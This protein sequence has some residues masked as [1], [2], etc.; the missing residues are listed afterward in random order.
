M[1]L[2]LTTLLTTV[3]THSNCVAFAILFTVLLRTGL[4][5][6]QTKTF[7]AHAIQMSEGGKK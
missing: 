7:A 6:P 2:S 3:R 5:R 4:G 1:D